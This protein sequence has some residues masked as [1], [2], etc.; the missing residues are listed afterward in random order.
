MLERLSSLKL[1][2]GN[3]LLKPSNDRCE[4]GEVGALAA[5]RSLFSGEPHLKLEALVVGLVCLVLWFKGMPLVGDFC[6]DD[7]YIT[8]S[9]SKN[10]AEGNGP[11]YSSGAKIEGYS[12]FL[13]M[14]LT[15][16]GERF[17]IGAMAAARGF[18]HLFFGLTL[19]ST[20]LLARRFGGALSALLVAV[21]LAVDSDFHRAIQSGLET[22]A[23]CGFL[24][25]GL[26]H[27][28][29][30]SK[31]KRRLSLL[32]FSAAALTRIDGFVPL[33]ILVG[34]EGLAWL[35]APS[36]AQ[37][38]RLAVWLVLGALPVIV[39]WIWRYNYYGLAF[40]LPYYAKA[41]AG[42]ESPEAGVDYLWTGL[43]ETGVWVFALVSVYGIS[44]RFQREL[45]VLGSFVLLLSG[46]VVYVGGDWMP[47]NRMLL[48]LMSPLF[49]LT[50][51]G[52]SRAFNRSFLD[53]AILTRSTAIAL[54]V[55]VGAHLTQAT[56]ITPAE[57]AKIG[58]AQWITSH[59]QGL[60]GAAPFVRAMLRSPGEKLVTDYGGVFAYGSRAEV[61]EMWGLANREI[62]LKGNHDGIRAMYGK[63]CV[64]CYA[65]FEPDY[66]HATVP[67]VKQSTSIH[68]MAQMVSSIFQGRAIDQV[69]NFQENYIVGRVV[70]EGTGGAFWFLERKRPGLSF[71]ARK[72][73]GFLVEYPFFGRA[74]PVPSR[75]APPR[76]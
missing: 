22:V 16:L 35:R 38:K 11:V 67:L 58:T 51:A 4:E 49:V 53:S 74:R 75:R 56:V 1:S 59:T 48:P 47:M 72:V 43:R 26:L 70:E 41:S 61:I 36:L 30:E 39:Y 20:W 66:F 42:I 46:Y 29:L 33:G 54:C 18:S 68:S 69:L 24:S 31:T 21:V 32:W 12:N 23:F 40:P 13:W 65:D 27:Y 44:G 3:A 57:K 55:Y 52:F 5:L 7:A 25:C 2:L 19:A 10:L 34:L 8:F 73:G 17:G 50:A 45:L 60:L 14:V 9:Y 63:T 37:F 62:A 6:I 64:P 28:S 76:R 15:A 71:E